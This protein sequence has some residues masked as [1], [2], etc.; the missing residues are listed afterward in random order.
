VPGR[1]APLR[2]VS[3][4]HYIKNVASSEIFSTWPRQSIIANVHAI[5]SFTLN[6]VYTEWYRGRGFNYTITSS[7]AHDQMFVHNR[8][9]FQSIS[10][11]VDEY[12]RYFIRIDGTTHPFFAQ[13]SDGR[14]S[15][16][17]GRLSQWGSVTL[18]NRGY[19][20]IQILRHY[21]RP[22]I[23]LHVA[24]EVIGLPNSFPGYSL[25]VGSCGAYVQK[26]QNQL[27]R[28]RGNFPGIPVISPADG[29]YGESTRRAVETFQRVFDMPVN[30]VIDIATWFRISHIFVAVTGKS[31]GV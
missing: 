28:I 1:T 9:I 30:G 24:P 18:A 5:V 19:S 8:T 12:F 15:V 10:D 13:Y 4:I 26:V 25:R 31:A 7:P 14:Q 21:Y 16:H 20:A 29:Q 11:V 22:R 2:V 17:P 27:N 3:F 6:R 23:H